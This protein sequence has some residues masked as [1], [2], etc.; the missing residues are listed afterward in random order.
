LIPISGTSWCDTSVSGISSM[1]WNRDRGLLNDNLDSRF[2]SLLDVETNLNLSTESNGSRRQKQS[3][4]GSQSR[5]VGSSSLKL[6]SECQLPTRVDTEPI[7]RSPW[8]RWTLNPIF[9]GNSAI[10]M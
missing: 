2:A 1:K 5:R 9:G 7:A 6:M 3:I 10:E 8:S 4:K